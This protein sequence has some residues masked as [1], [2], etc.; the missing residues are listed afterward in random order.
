[1]NHLQ[2][3]WIDAFGSQRW[4]SRWKRELG[5][6]MLTLSQH[7]PLR[8]QFQIRCHRCQSFM[9]GKNLSFVTGSS[10]ESVTWHAVQKYCER[11]H[12]CNV[13][14][15]KNIP[16]LVTKGQLKFKKLLYHN[17]PTTPQ[18]YVSK[19]QL[20]NSILHNWGTF[21]SCRRR[22]AFVCL[23]IAKSKK[24]LRNWEQGACLHTGTQ[25]TS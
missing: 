16:L 5:S 6:A 19:T 4:S 21:G 11:R 17:N 13:L 2:T 3:W 12:H 22:K 23:K 1:M 18:Q 9:D 15:P 14:P 10:H 7:R 24:P 20:L 8:S 25:N